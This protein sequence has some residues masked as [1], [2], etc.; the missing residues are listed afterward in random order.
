MK[1]ENIIR[2]LIKYRLYYLAY[3]FLSILSIF[4]GRFSIFKFVGNDLWLQKQG[5][6]FFCDYSPNYRLKQKEIDSFSNEIF[7]N[8][9]QPKK[10][11]ICID[12]G[13]GLGLETRL[14]SNMIGHEGRVFAIEATERTYKALENCIYY[15]KLNNGV[16]AR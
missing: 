8:G 6:I 13:A 4:L 11:D 7:F 15:N 3:F 9:Y 16:K 10:G 2:F 14:M 1:V 12:I 5:K